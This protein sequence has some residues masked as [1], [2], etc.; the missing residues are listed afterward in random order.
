[1]PRVVAGT[2]SNWLYR[3]LSKRRASLK[4]RECR[5]GMPAGA[6]CLDAIFSSSDIDAVCSFNYGFH[7]DFTAFPLPD[8]Q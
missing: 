1:M 7:G 6:H 8:Q 3:H 4:L 2:L 5:S